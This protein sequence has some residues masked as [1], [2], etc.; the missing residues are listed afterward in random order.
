M[1]RLPSEEE[2][3]KMILAARP[4]DEQDILMCCIHLLG[5]I[6][7]ALRIRWEDVNFEQKVVVLWTRKRKDGAYE[8]DEQPMNQDLYDVLKGRWESRTQETWAFYNPDTGTRYFHRPKMMASICKRAGIAPLGKTK[9]RIWRGKK[10]GTCRDVDLYYGFHALRH[11]MASH[12]VDQEKVSLKSV[13]RL[14]R[15]KTLK[16][17][18][19]YVHSIEESVRFAMGSVEGKFTLKSEEAHPIVT[20]KKE[21]EATDNS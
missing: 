20:P 10:K 13:S 3:L 11:F 9:R 15:H 2:I 21:K 18:E 16:T 6:D 5:R 17:T 8:P 14:L 1:K 12:L 4:G 7:E 19:I